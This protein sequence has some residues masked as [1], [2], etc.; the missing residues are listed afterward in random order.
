MSR[1]E[2][3]EFLAAENR[4]RR[5]MRSLRERFSGALGYEVSDENFLTEPGGPPVNIGIPNS[6]RPVRLRTFQRFHQPGDFVE[7]HH[8]PLEA[9]GR[10]VGDGKLLMLTLMWYSGLQGENY[11]RW[12]EVDASV[13]SLILE[14]SRG[15]GPWRDGL[16]LCVCDPKVE[17]GFCLREGTN[18]GMDT[19]YEDHWTLE[20]FGEKW[21]PIAEN[22]FEF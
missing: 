1:Q 18:W 21:V 17:N 13:F 8:E 4:R 3:I 7:K 22:L 2:R 20:V 5:H 9:F 11:A 10:R 12:L 14:W 15:G 19:E 16:W 6:S